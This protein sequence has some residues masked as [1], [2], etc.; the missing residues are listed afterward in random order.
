MSEPTDARF[1]LNAH[2]MRAAL[3]DI[4]DEEWMNDRLPDDD[5]SI[6]PDHDVPSEDE[7]DDIAE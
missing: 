2:T 4:V 1:T 3:L 6:P 5:I 7:V